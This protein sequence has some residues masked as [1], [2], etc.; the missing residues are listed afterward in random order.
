[1]S[2]NISIVQFQYF[3]NELWKIESGHLLK[4]H[5]RVLKVQVVGALSNLA[6]ALLK[7]MAVVIKMVGYTSCVVGYYTIHATTLNVKFSVVTP[8]HSGGR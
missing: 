6:C 1:M 3:L 4:I 2:K 8:L 7:L 5:I